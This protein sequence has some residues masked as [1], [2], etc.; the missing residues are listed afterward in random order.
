M[1]GHGRQSVTQLRHTRN[2]LRPRFVIRLA[3]Q[4]SRFYRFMSY[5]AEGAGEDM[6][7]ARCNAVSTSL[8]A[9]SCAAALF[10][11]AGC[12][13]SAP[14]IPDLSGQWGRDW[15]FFEPPASGPGPVIS[16]ERRPD[17]TLVDE[18]MI[19]DPLNPILRPAAAEAV[20]RQ[21]EINRSGRLAPD[22]HNQCWPEPPPFTLSL[23]FG[24]QIL[25]ERD[26]VTFTY[27]A[28][29][30]VRH[31]RLNV[32][33]AENVIPTW[34]GDSVGRFEGD[35]LVIDTVGIKAGPFATVD[36][37]GTPYSEALH[38][39]ERYR[40][41]DGKA[42]A[43]AQD[44]HMRTYFDPTGDTSKLPF[45]ALSPFYGRGPLDPDTN[46]PGLQV[47]IT[48]EDPGMFTTPWAALVTYRPVLA[49]PPVAWPEAICAEGARQAFGL[50]HKIPTANTP[51][52]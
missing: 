24:V 36:Q 25:Q 26:K 44:R 48:V 23:Q 21:G 2:A 9:L 37:Y 51:D 4:C 17:G 22:A 49:E 42:A 6:I 52:F 12:T 35:T 40:L 31:V 27:L 30:H 16:I 47:E 7:T 46:H 11:L 5:A 20:R 1:P 50:E 18:P 10:C 28:D 34:E 29:Q 39:I 15:F 38:V 13:E 43:D 45:E 3:V 19:G 41:I 32:P 8:V 14:P 33:H